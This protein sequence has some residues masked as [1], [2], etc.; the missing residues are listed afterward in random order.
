MHTFNPVSKCTALDIMLL[1]CSLTGPHTHAML[2]HIDWSKITMLQQSQFMH[3]RSLLCEPKLLN[4]TKY[5][6]SEHT[7]TL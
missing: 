7:V 2:K 4:K 6:I 3:S 1:L 5:S